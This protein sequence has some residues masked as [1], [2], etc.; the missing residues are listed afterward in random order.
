MNDYPFAKKPAFFPSVGA[1]L[2][3]EAEDAEVDGTILASLDED[4]MAELDDLLETI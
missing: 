4:L 1:E 3:F 2:F